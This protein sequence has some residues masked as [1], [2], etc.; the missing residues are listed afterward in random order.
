MKYILRKGAAA[1]LAICMMI[2]LAPALPG[3]HRP[4]AETEAPALQ[5]FAYREGPS[6]DELFRDYVEQMFF[7]EEAA[8]LQARTGEIYLSGPDRI[9]YDQLI[10]RALAVADGRETNTVVRIPASV[11]MPGKNG[12]TARELGVSS[13]IDEKGTGISEEALNA[14]AKLATPDMTK[15]M[16]CLY[17]DYSSAFYWNYGFGWMSD[18]IRV[19][20]GLLSIS[21]YY[22][23][24]MVA[25]G[26]QNTRA[27]DPQTVFNP[28]KVQRAQQARSNALR[29]VDRY[30]GKTDYEK[31][32]GYRKEICDLVEYDYNAVEIGVDEATID[33]WRIVNVFDGD[34]ST[35]AVCEGYARAFQYLVSQSSFRSSYMQS[36]LVTGWMDGGDHMWN[37]VTMDDGKNYLVDVTNCDENGDERSLFLK[38]ARGSYSAGYTVDDVFYTYEDEVKDLYGNKVLTLSTADYRVRPA[39]DP[40]PLPDNPSPSPSGIRYPDVPSGHWAYQAVSLATEQGIF[41]GYPD[42][43]FY[44]DAAVTRAQF[45][46]LL[47]RMA[48]SPASNYR[49]SFTDVSANSYYAA[50]VRWGAENGYVLGV[51][52]SN[53]TFSY[54]PDDR[55]TREQAMTFLYR[56]DG[57]EPG[58]AASHFNEYMRAFRDSR[59][60]SSYAQAP[61]VWALYNGYVN[62]FNDRTLRPQQGATRAQVASILVRYMG[63]Q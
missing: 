35:D 63:L 34:R 58:E 37:V 52:N 57:E 39:S 54:R 3:T 24:L 15:V 6:G 28:S 48:G 18:G 42:G 12:Y 7:P 32:D 45:I 10:D 36:I 23:Y 31:V 53:G 8:E 26:Y 25:P 14:F 33:P 62:G 55:V 30:A 50:A 47:W 11:L 2:S 46:T 13:L 17:N 4:S 41:Q 43:R 44:P 19:S 27:E 56:Y 61:I 9:A 59:N 5:G 1:M 38:A 60:I 21:N 40:Y 20:G 51:Q 29:I 16:T 49:A 22:V